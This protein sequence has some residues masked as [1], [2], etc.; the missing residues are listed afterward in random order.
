VSKKMTIKK[1]HSSTSTVS[2][3]FPRRQTL[4]LHIFGTHF[5]GQHDLNFIALFPGSVLGGPDSGLKVTDVTRYW[6]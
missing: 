5:Q 1:F 6:I 4:V 3:A 2:I